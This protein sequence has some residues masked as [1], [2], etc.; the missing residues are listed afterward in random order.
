MKSWFT[1]NGSKSIVIERAMNKLESLV[2]TNN[3]TIEE[4]ITTFLDIMDHLDIAKSSLLLTYQVR[5][6]K[7]RIINPLYAPVVYKVRD[8]LIDSSNVSMQYCYNRL[9]SKEN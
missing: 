2:L 3:T 4:Y 9:C 1:D 5:S 6:F 8:M 7:K